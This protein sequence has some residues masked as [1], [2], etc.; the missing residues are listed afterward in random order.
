MWSTVLVFSI[1]SP[2]MVKLSLP[3]LRSVE[4]KAPPAEPQ[5]GA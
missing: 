5:A 2:V 3:Y 1:A 4:A